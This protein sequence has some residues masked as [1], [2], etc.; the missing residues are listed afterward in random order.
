MKFI[1]IISISLATTLLLTTI[2]GCSTMRNMAIEDSIKDT[3]DGHDS[4]KVKAFE[5]RFEQVLNDI[6]KKEDYKKLP[7]DDTD[8]TKWLIQESFKLWNK[9]ISK[10]EYIKAGIE[11]YSGYKE[12]LEYL[13]NEF[14]Q[15]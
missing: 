12:T 6:D 4:Q 15:K 8:K 3:K 9:E 14:S 5:A 11:K 10:E 7:T 1:K 2:S 13:A